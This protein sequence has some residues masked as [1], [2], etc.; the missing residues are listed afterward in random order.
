VGQ[1]EQLLVLA[2]DRFEAQDYDGALKN[3][4]LA[5][6]SLGSE[7][8]EVIAPSPR[9][10]STAPTPAGSGSVCVACGAPLK[11][12]DAFCRKCGTKVGPQSC[13]ACGADVAADDAF[14]RKCGTRVAR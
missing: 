10:P 11:V 4:R 12:D 6:R 7:K 9:L 13:S 3:A 1:A 2:K 5:Q 8:V 14:C